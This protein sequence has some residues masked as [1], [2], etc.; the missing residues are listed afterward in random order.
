MN[1]AGRDFSLLDAFLHDALGHLQH[2][3]GLSDGQ[4]HG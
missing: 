2:P 3:G 4:W 1:A